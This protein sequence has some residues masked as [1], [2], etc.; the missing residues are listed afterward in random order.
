VR[1]NQSELAINA[2]PLPQKGRPSAASTAEHQ[3]AQRLI[4]AESV[5]PRLKPFMAMKRAKRG[6]SGLKVCD[7]FVN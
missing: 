4:K 5:A 1:R 2:A 3:L 6:P 7:G